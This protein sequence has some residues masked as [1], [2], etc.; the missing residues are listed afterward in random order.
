MILPIILAGGYGTRLWPISREAYPKQFL[1]LVGDYSLLQETL[2]RTTAVA[3]MAEPIITCHAEHYFFCVSQIEEINQ[4]SHFV[5]EPCSRNTAPAI[6]AS[7]IDAM[8][9]YQCDPL[10]LVMPS[11]H[12][13]GDV[14]A[15]QQV[16]AVAVAAAEEDKLITFGIVPTSAKT[17][18][19]YIHAG[20]IFSN[21]S[22]KV[23]AFT[24]KPER[25][26]AE[27]FIKSGDYFW[28]SGMF[29]FKATAFLRELSHYH[30][31]IESMVRRSVTQGNRRDNLIHLDKAQFSQCEAISIDYAVMEKTDNA[32]MMP[33]H[34][35]WTDLGCWSS[36][37][38]AN[39]ADKDHNVIIGDVE[40]YETSNCYLR[41]ENKNLS[42]VGLKDH[43]V[44]NTKDSVLVAHKDFS[45][46][47]KEIVE[48][49]KSH[50]RQL[51][52]APQRMYYP[53]GYDES[54]IMEPNFH[55]KSMMVKPGAEVIMSVE[56]NYSQHWVVVAGIAQTVCD[57]ETQ[58]LKTGQSMIVPAQTKHGIS[59]IG[60]VPLYL[61]A[62]KCI[63]L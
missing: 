8:Q 42:T 7:A 25:Q 5:I 10:L 32:L 50:R 31:E 35:E 43:I 2:L 60:E 63:A 37:A 11:D 59:N 21:G 28:N 58:L 39:S 26:R 3:G 4:H 23:E 6:A 46:Q 49:L 52:E 61:I 41:S 53:W 1:R 36:V 44:I 30:S 56:Q 13:I 12:Y 48:S 14:E 45:Q 24:E 16:V 20:K 54:L 18:Y 34:A 62:V 27:A 57:D 33:M 15:F 51:T 9:R 17:G 22:R 19:G 47:V 29:V 40:T 38:E 55:V